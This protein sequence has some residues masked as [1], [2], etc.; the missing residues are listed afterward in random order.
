MALDI[1]QSW[2]DA[3][4]KLSAIKTTNELKQN[5]KTLK[6][7]KAN[8]AKEN[9]QSF[10]KRL[11]DAKSGK[12]ENKKQIK[13]EEKNQLELL[14]ELFKESLPKS[15]GQSLSL[16]T[17]IFLESS[18]NTKEKIKE[19]LID[20]I[21]STIGCSEEQSY[22][23]SVNQ[24][25]YIKVNQIDLFNQLKTSP[26]DEVAKVFYE[27]A[28]TNNGS[29]PYA[30]NRQ[31]YQ[32][33]QVPNQS[34]SQDTSAGNGQTYVSKSQAQLFDIEY[35]QNYTNQQN[36]LVTG[37][38]YKV[39]LNSQLNNKTSVSDFLRDYYGSIDILSFD[40]LS[41]NLKSSIT[42]SFDVGLGLS[43]GEVKNKFDFF[44]ILKRLMG[45]CNDPTKKIDVAGTAKLS[46][47]DD[48]D[49][50]FFE[51]TPQEELLSDKL[52]NNVK[53]GVVEFED[54][55]NVE[56]PVNLKSDLANQ[57]EIVKEKNDT[58]KIELFNKFINDASK[59]PNWQKI[60]QK[61]GFSI[62][63]FDLNIKSSI[64]TSIITKLP[65]VIFKSILTPKVMLGFF[66]MIKAIK[67]EL[68][69]TIDSKYDDLKNFFKTF[70][71]FVVNFLRK[72]M[73]IFVETLFNVVKKN[74]KL[75]VETI[76]SEIIKESKIKKLRMYS[77]ILYILLQLTQSFIDFR[78][79]KSVID[80]ILNL[81]NL[82]I[83]G[84]GGG[85]IPSFI[86]ASSALLGGVSD[87]RAMS[88]V[89]Q[90]LQSAGLPTGAAPDGG[91]NLMNI[92][93]LS[94]IQG[95][96]L[97]NAQH[98]LTEVWIPPTPVTPAGVTL[99]TKGFGKSY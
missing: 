9:S 98:S 60:S 84:V 37:D 99:P 49:D 25:I 6:K 76:I 39:T 75:L 51:P 21:V 23:T 97:E 90:N 59:D 82:G 64:Q 65:S 35:V 94:M 42:G 27:D 69:E 17:K 31:L 16:I 83:T 43:Q 32:R 24:P 66:I 47:V 57:E 53:K 80:E 48:I 61:Y 34:F 74:I 50:S 78:N 58:K 55:G 52:S 22:D 4:K 71:K 11:S 28:Q 18:S 67:N 5:E 79:C 85:G 40:N 92:A 14:L 19:I 36:V 73:A 12:K 68:S 63:S 96:S 41:A 33:L 93:M 26:D 29:L 89:I 86:L 95:Q 54:C 13:S 70:K 1:K 10:K 8:S 20:E 87:T 30:M 56:L 2:G 62:P 44:A 3:S 91:P 77:T 46:D 38:F 45:V 88:N 7:N 81:L 15:G 72:L